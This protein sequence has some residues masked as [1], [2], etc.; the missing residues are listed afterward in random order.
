MQRFGSVGFS[1][2][3]V[4]IIISA[5]IF[6]S[7]SLLSSSHSLIVDATNDNDDND[8]NDSDQPRASS[9]SVRVLRNCTSFP[10]TPSPI[11][12]RFSGSG[13]PLLG[14]QPLQVATWELSDARAWYSGNGHCLGRSS[15]LSHYFALL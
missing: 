3:S 5:I 11:L 13:K 12:L 15:K 7:L 6:I 9:H 14:P 4:T 1:S 8:I 2:H 10:G